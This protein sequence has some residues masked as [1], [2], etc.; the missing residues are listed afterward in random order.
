MSIEG[1][2]AELVKLQ[3][4]YERKSKRFSKSAYVPPSIKGDALAKITRRMDAV[5][6]ELSALSE[7]CVDCDLRPAGPYCADC[8]WYT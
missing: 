1:L 5:E 8:R 6:K 3:G 2:R 7:H 4:D